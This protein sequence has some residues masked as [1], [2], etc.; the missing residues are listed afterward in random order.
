ML[1]SILLL[2]IVLVGI[3]VMVALTIINYKKVQDIQSRLNGDDT[4]TD[5]RINSMINGINFNDDKLSMASKMMENNITILNT[6]VTTIE[7]QQTKNSQDV[8]YLKQQ[9]ASVFPGSIS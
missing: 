2:M 7:D 8:A 1:G 4:S 9:Y 3:G 6:R 5:V